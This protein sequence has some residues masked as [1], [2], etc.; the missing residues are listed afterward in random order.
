MTPAKL[1]FFYA[2][3]LFRVSRASDLVLAVATY[4][5]HHFM[6]NVSRNTWRKGL[7]TIVS[8]ES[9][10]V[11]HVLEEQAH[12]NELWVAGPDGTGY[13]W[14][15]KGG[16]KA[17]QRCTGVLRVAN[18]TAGLYNWILGGDDDVVWLLDNVKQLVLRLDANKPY[19][20]T[21]GFLND[22]WTAC[23]LLHEVSAPLRTGD[24]VRA[25]ATQPCTR[26]ELE[27]PDVC[28]SDLLRGKQPG[29][30]TAGGVQ[31]GAYGN[32]GYIV[33]RALMRSISLEDWMA[34]E[35]CNTSRFN[36]MYG[37]DFRIGECFLAFGANGAGIGPTLPTL[38]GI[39]VFGHDLLQL[40]GLAEGV[41]ASGNC[42][43]SCIAVL[44]TVVSVSISE[45]AMSRQDYEA[46]LRHFHDVY[47]RAKLVLQRTIKRRVPNLAPGVSPF[48]FD[49]ATD[50]FLLST[51]EP[52][53]GERL[54]PAPFMSNYRE[55]MR[56]PLNSATR[57]LR[58]GPFPPLQRGFTVPGFKRG[59][60][61]II[62]VSKL[63]RTEHARPAM[64]SRFLPE[65]GAFKAMLASLNRSQPLFLHAFARD[66]W[67]HGES[68]YHA[69]F[70][71]MVINWMGHAA[72]VGLANHVLFVSQTAKDCA[73][74]SLF[75]PCIV[76]SPLLAHPWPNMH[77]FAANF[78]WIYAYL[79]LQA[80][81]DTVSLDTDALLLRNP[82]PFL[83]RGREVAGISDATLAPNGT[84]DC[85]ETSHPCQNTGFTYLRS[86]PRVLEAVANMTL[87][88]DGGFEQDVW[89]S[90][91]ALGLAT[92][93]AYELLPLTGSD[94]FANWED[95]VSGMLDKNKMSFNL[96]LLHL[97]KAGNGNKKEFQFRCMQ[98]WFDE[99]NLEVD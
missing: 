20:I 39:R 40:Q 11:E 12:A 56:D 30:W 4:S 66:V 64:P 73:E 89:S 44:N 72:H 84:A 82:V 85:G 3:C 49:V 53:P 24:C 38:D 17:E 9:E 63:P 45:H 61:P 69:G 6:L 23:A 95:V 48:S 43:A 26:A 98:L 34:C 10:G 21:D 22:V 36:C 33:S 27:R 68:E 86:T 70:T 35:Q 87:S 75:A 29:T 47:K 81:Y 60:F 94:V 1:F 79:L 67:Q 41:V 88:F 51:V 28:R 2:T 14:E 96:T 92:Q 15:T 74:V 80:G 46:K 37:A 83:E 91:H 42:D 31:M 62:H 99:S 5:K 55:C 19:F 32:A 65:P 59:D 13:G 93:G 76:N 57:H 16:N 58:Y 50:P 25:K 18:A 54:L 97:G 7:F 71:P 90:I 78:R 77:A 52:T 8:T